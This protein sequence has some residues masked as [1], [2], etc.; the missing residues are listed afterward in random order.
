MKKSKKIILGIA[1]L[2]ALLVASV[3]FNYVFLSEHRDIA[4]EDASMRMA[5]TALY[6]DFASNETK[7]TAQ[8]LD[9]VI[10]IE[11][12]I[13]SI[14]PNEIILD[15]QVQVG[16]TSAIETDKKKGNS[17]QLKGRCVGYDELLEVVKID[18]A[19][20]TTYEN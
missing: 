16:F 18:Q 17:L 3:V 11:G 6:A 15:N 19:T 1:F 4:S 8:Y 12:I 13:T 5:A 2:F 14:Q 7:A 10:E 20:L 9:K